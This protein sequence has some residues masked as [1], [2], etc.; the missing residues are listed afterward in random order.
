[1][2]KQIEVLVIDNEED[3]AIECVDFLQLKC[4]INATFALTA[5]EAIEKLKTLPIKIILLDYD[6]PVNGLDLFPKLKE[7]D[8]CVEFV[9]I[10]AVATNDV[11]YKAEKY[12]FSA[13]IEK[14]RCK[15]ELQELIPILLMR[16]TKKINTTSKVFFSERKNKLFGGHRIEYS[17]CSYDIINKAYIPDTW[18]TTQMIQAGEKLEHI[19]ETD[20]ERILNFSDNFKLDCELNTELNNSNFILALSSQLESSIKSDYSEKIKTAIKRIRE[21]SLSDKKDNGDSSIVAR[22]YDFTNV[23]YEI[24]IRINKHCTCCN[25]DNILLTTAYFPIPRIAYRIREYFD[26]KEPKII[27]SGFYET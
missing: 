25:C 12:H 16:Y 14:G 13:K 2:D 22:Y 17:I 7:I 3:F 8:P 11:L 4:H 21:I 1:M 19:E 20:Y 24:K 27:D 6:M 15:D 18:H 26:G 23:Y 9:F 10:S 5:D